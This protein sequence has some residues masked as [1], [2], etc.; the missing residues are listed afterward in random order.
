[1]SEWVQWDDEQGYDVEEEYERGYKRETR[2]CQHCGAKIHTEAEICPHCG[3]RVRRSRSAS[4]KNPGLAAA[5]S[6]L[7]VGLGQ[8]YNGQIGKGIVFFLIG[9]ILAISVV[10]II[11]FILYPVF[12]IYNIYDAHNTA[13]KINAGEI[14]V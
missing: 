12:W 7:F 10:I 1:M 2:F 9:V 11:G 5:F 8:I 6:F 13:K 3:A 4:Q 14:I